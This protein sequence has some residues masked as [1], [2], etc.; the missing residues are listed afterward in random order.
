[1]W[2]PVDI[3]FEYYDIFL[4]LLNEKNNTCFSNSVTSASTSAYHDNNGMS[5]ERILDDP[6]AMNDMNKSTFLGD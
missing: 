4:Y 1:M 6:S 5:T 2:Q 3:P